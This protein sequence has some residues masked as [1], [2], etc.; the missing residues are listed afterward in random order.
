MTNSRR[1]RMAILIL[2]LGATVGCDQTSKHLARTELGPTGY[3]TLPGGFG[4]LRLAENAGSFLSLGASFPQSFRLAIFTI[5][6]GLGLFLLFGYLV[7]QAS[8]GWVSFGGHTLVMAGGMS[9]LIDRVARQGFV[10]DFIFVRVGP[11]HTGIFNLADVMIMA[12]IGAIAFAFWRRGAATEG[13]APSG[14][15]QQSELPLDKTE[16]TGCRR[17]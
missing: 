17:P 1:L 15:I 2:L 11:L 10:T 4:E 14:P 5:G 16:I 13:A 8:L 9:N 7:R 6:V 3:I 12:G